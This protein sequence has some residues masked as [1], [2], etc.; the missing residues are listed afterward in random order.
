VALNVRSI[1]VDRIR[2]VVMGMVILARG[3]ATHP[4]TQFWVVSQKHLVKI[5]PHFG[6]SGNSCE[7]P[8]I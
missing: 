5:R 1:G 8:A 3:E 7:S 4:Q 2:G 6:S